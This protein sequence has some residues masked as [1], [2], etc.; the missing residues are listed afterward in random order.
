MLAVVAEL[1]LPPVPQ[2]KFLLGLVE[3]RL[4]AA[5]PTTN[6]VR[7]FILIH[8]AF[9]VHNTMGCVDHG[10]GIAVIGK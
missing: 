4:P 6:G 10:W 1:E 8:H 3:Y 2:S 9:Y 7:G 5:D